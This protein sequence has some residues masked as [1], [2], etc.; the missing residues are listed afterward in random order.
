MTQKLQNNII[1]KLISLYSAQAKIRNRKDHLSRTIDFKNVNASLSLRQ[2]EALSLINSDT[3]CGITKLSSVLSISKP[4]VS[5]LISKLESNKL[6]TID[7]GQDKRQKKIQ[8]TSQGKILAE[9]HDR[10][11]SEAVKGY[12][13][14]LD[15]FDHNELLVIEKFIDALS[16]HIIQK[17]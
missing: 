16:Q 14:I 5:R 15:N 4:A 1:K 3:Q 9:Q 12:L 10:L 13:G 11:H 6:I 2:L 8:L 17:K 7:S